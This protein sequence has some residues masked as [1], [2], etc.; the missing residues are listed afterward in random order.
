MENKEIRRFCV[1]FILLNSIHLMIFQVC[2][3]TLDY[4]ISAIWLL[5]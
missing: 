4:T 3:L 2:A 1:I 5:I